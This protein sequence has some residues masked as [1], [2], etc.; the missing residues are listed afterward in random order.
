MMYSCV[1]NLYIYHGHEGH[2]NFDLLMISSVE[3]VY[4]FNY[5]KKQELGAQV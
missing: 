1:I 4:S 3:L 5:F 2:G